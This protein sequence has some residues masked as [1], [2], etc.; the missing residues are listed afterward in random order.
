MA[1]FDDSIVPCPSH[2]IHRHL[3]PPLKRCAILFRPARR[4]SRECVRT[5]PSLE[6]TRQFFPSY[7]ALR[8]RLRAGLDYF[9]PTALDFRQQI[10]LANTKFASR[11]HL[12][13]LA[14]RPSSHKLWSPIFTEIWSAHVAKLS[15]T[16]D[17]VSQNQQWTA[18]STI[19][20]IA[21]SIA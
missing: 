15:T 3:H 21:L 18:Q 6:G 11:T 17:D 2:P 10:P 4:D 13:C 1:H 20:G 16:E 5:V 8:L 9:S 14:G 12:P 7:P 19:L